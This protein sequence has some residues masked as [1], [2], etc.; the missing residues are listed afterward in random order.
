MGKSGRTMSRDYADHEDCSDFKWDAQCGSLMP[1]VGEVQSHAQH[2]YFKPSCFGPAVFPSSSGMQL[3][4]RIHLNRKC[5]RVKLQL[6]NKKKRENLF[7]FAKKGNFSN[8]DV[9][10]FSRRKLSSHTILENLSQNKIFSLD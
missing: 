2:C 10:F 8:V 1:D 3:R 7:L 5:F 6:Q 4:C 9:S